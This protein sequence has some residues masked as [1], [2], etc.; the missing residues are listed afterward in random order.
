MKN[1]DAAQNPVWLA[2]RDRRRV[3]AVLCSQSACFSD[4]IKTAGLNPTTDFRFAN[5]SAV[6]FYGSDLRGYDFTGANLSE[7]RWFCATWDKTTI[8][9][10][11]ILTD[12]RGLESIE[13]LIVHSSADQ[14]LAEE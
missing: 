10:D 9:K 6:D 4:L 2:P 8:L 3:E 11:S 7:T 12:S 1:E 13:F 5:L 14:A